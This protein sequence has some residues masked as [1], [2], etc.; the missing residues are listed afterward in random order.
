[1]SQDEREA[2]AER[3]REEQAELDAAQGPPEVDEPDDEIEPMATPTD[4]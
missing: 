1:M 3:L 2:L 4:D